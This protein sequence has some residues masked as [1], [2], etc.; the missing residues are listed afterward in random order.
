MA[1]AA[2]RLAQRDKDIAGLDGPRIV[3]DP[4]DLRVNPGD[5]VGPVRLVCPVRPV[6][7]VG[8]VGPTRRADHLFPRQRVQ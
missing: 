2:R 4:A 5:L 7:L 3:D 6:R 1:V 8:T